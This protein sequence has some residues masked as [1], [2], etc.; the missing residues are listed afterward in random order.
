VARGAGVPAHIWHLKVAGKQNWGRMSEVSRL[1]SRFRTEG[2]DI[3]A[4]MYPYTASAARL[5]ALIPTWVQD[6]GRGKMLERLKDPT[7]RAKIKAE[8]ESNVKGP[9]NFYRGTGPEGIMIASV[10]NPD[11]KQFEGAMLRTVA[12]VW[13]KHPIDALMDLLLA[14]SA[15]I[16]A[17]YFEMNEQDV[18]M[19]MAQPWAAFNTDAEGVAIDGPLSTGKTHPRAYGSFTR[20]LKKY[21]REDK[22]LTLEEAIRKMTSLPAQRVGLVDRGLVKQGFYADLV[23]FDPATVADKA[24]FEQPHQYSEGIS[25]VVI[26]GQPVWE[27]GAFTGNLPGRVLKGSA[28]TK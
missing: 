2:L 10:E 11:L 23:L 8:L 27:N 24:T 19:A 12:T 6:G 16:G 21:V 25:L 5:A 7:V 28:A 17:I 3:T 26:N 13:K 4:D 9:E 15:R 20:V 18:R 1:I 14:D 22:V